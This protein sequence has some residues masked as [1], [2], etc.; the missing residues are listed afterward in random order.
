MQP[1]K[2]SA[3]IKPTL[4]TKFH[5]D[6]NWWSRERPSD[7]RTYLLSHLPPEKR[8]YFQ[9]KSGADQILDYIHPDTA[10]VMRLDEL[11][12]A[13]QEAASQPDF[14]NSHTS[15]V[16]SLFRVFIANGN[17]PRSPLELAIATGRDAQTILKTVGGPKVYMGIRPYL[18][19]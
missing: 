9:T 17:Q 15:L 13:L 18:D 5:I 12:L 10:E 2:P 6:Y 1:G 8:S 7:L 3:L 16:D 14:I 11:G 4:E 19:S